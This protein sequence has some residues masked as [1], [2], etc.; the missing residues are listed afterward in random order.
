M[1][2]W[3]EVVS[4]IDLPSVLTSVVSG[5]LVVLLIEGVNV[6]RKWHQR[7]S[8]VSDLRTFFLD[9]QTELESV[10]G[11]EDGQI[12]REAFQFALWTAHLED[13]H[14]VVASHGPHLPREHLVEITEVLAGKQRLANM[15][16]KNAAPSSNLYDQ[17]FERLRTVHWLNMDG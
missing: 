8:A 12:P 10:Q 7:R 4:W 16:P 1:P 15:L 14:V 6:L 11:S 5:V 2:S 13:A 17:Y 9:F 3:C